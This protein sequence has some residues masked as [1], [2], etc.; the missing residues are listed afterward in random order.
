M[1][2]FRNTAVLP[3]DLYFALSRFLDSQK[4]QHDQ[5]TTVSRQ[6]YTKSG[7][8]SWEEGGYADTR[9]KRLHRYSVNMRAKNPLDKCEQRDRS[10]SPTNGAQNEPSVQVQV[11]KLDSCRIPSI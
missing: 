3:A 10:T 5:K 11:P 8:D 4:K 7:S 9:H 6:T 2:Y 1:D